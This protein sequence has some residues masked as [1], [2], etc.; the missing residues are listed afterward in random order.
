MFITIQFTSFLYFDLGVTGGLFEVC[1][2]PSFDNFEIFPVQMLRT[3]VFVLHQ[4]TMCMC[5]F[6]STMEERIGKA[7]RE[8]SHNKILEDL[9]K[10]FGCNVIVV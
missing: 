10:E 5:P 2:N 4:R 1:L 9:E 8:Y 3:P 6:N 7:L